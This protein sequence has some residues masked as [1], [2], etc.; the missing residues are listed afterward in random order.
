MGDPIEVEGIS[1]VFHHKTGRPTLIGAIKPSLGHSEGASGIT[2]IMKVVLA[3]EQ[4]TVPATT[5]VNNIKPSIKTDE[6]NV[7]IAMAHCQ[8]PQSLVP[9]ASVNSFGFG[10]AN[11]HAILEAP[12]AHT[13]VQNGHAA[14]LNR[15]SVSVQGDTDNTDYLLAFSARTELSLKQMV[16]DLASHVSQ[17]NE[18]IDLQDLAYT[19]SRHRSRLTTRGYL[20]A[21]QS[22]LQIDLDP[23]RLNIENVGVST[24][25][26]LAFVYTG[27]GA[28]WAGMGWRLIHQ[29]PVFR[30]SIRC[31]DSCLR[32]LGSDLAP[33]WNL[34]ASLL[35]PVEA[36]DIHLAEKS[37]PVCTAVQ[38]ALTDLLHN[39][40]VL[41]K[42]VI[43]HSSGEIG[44]AYAA[45]HLTA[46]QAI[47]TAFCRGLA[48]SK[49]QSIG[50]MVAVGLS[51]SRAQEIINELALQDNINVACINSP[52]SCTVSGDDAAIEKLHDALQKRKIF[53][54][55][56]KTNG[57]AYHSHHMKAVGPLY[58]SMLESVWHAPNDC[59]NG[60]AK[61][62]SNSEKTSSVQMVS[63]VTGM[64]VTPA[65]VSSPAYW[66]E[67]LESPVRF[68]DA[69]RIVLE[70]QQHHFIEVGPH[71]SLKLPIEQTATD[72]DKAHENYL[73][74]S[75]LVRDR[76][77]VVTALNL[78]G[79]L[80]LHGHDEVL[81][82]KTI[83]SG[84][85]SVAQRPSFLV[86]LPTYPWD[87]STPT[88]WHEPRSVTEFRNRRYPRHELLGSQMPGGSKLT[89]TWRSI[90]D[91]KEVDW[92]KDHRLGPSIVFPAPAYLAMAVEAMCQVSGLQL[93]ECPGIE[94]RNFTF[95]KALDLDPEQ[96]PRV[97]IFTEMRQERISST[98]ASER[99][100]HFSVTSVSGNDAYPTAHANGLVRLSKRSP[101]SVH[102]QIELKRTNMEQQATRVWYDKF[103]KE[104]L[105]WGP[106]FAVMEEIFCDRARQAHH[107]SATTH[108]LCGNNS[109]PGGRTQYIAH[110]I[111]ID[112]MLQTA[113]VATTGGWVKNLQ[114]TVP[115]T[116]DSVHVSAPAM[117]DMSTGEQWSIDAVSE[118]VGFGTVRIDAELHNSSNQVLMRMNNVR[119]IAYQGNVQS[120]V[121]E[122]R[123]P[124][125]RVAWKPNITAFAAGANADF[126]KY[127]DWFAESCQTGGMKED[128]PSKRIAAA[129]DLVVHKWPNMRIL[130][131]GGQPEVSGLF[132]DV[133]RAESPL[134]RFSSYVRGIPTAKG[135]LLGL[136][137][138]TGEISFAEDS[139]TAESLP[140]DKKFDLVIF[141]GV[142][143][144][145]KRVVTVEFVINANS[146]G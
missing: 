46:R 135:E 138:L 92:L 36:S 109:G 20:L 140:M 22:S 101:A 87:Y 112:S 13:P 102:R 7:E 94:L 58:Q 27:Q 133:L 11:S 3:L 85:E 24:K 62:A 118:R 45:D 116:M 71:P 84:P 31:L 127:L 21:S 117:L 38:I 113:F 49:S 39:W 103:T 18:L 19:L 44:A 95:L 42:V 115:V 29:Y 34:E 88:P 122:Q 132:I 120:E 80:F 5:G 93:Y 121:V 83:A 123:N 4:H 48:V 16:V 107:A 1:R 37:Q 15:H 141:S 50:A 51:Q 96:R 89:T 128:G 139:R 76:D 54:R 57:K 10:G 144:V 43:G 69:V 30:N 86:D 52:E 72:L 129:L 73:H 64:N 26:P 6:W 35:A 55:K 90:L 130:E 53:A 81:F 14:L 106:Q 59:A 134:R 56:L 25:H 75:V 137:A 61:D 9:R 119:C 100:W 124:L 142:S 32:T 97:E 12:D 41:P 23:S 63:T 126:S 145:Y 40:G 8:W 47:M 98:T 108:L 104:G 91:I 114:A 111:S 74:S 60:L 17:L 2:S 28:Q 70:G 136:E 66:R 68:E 77:A 33:P 105:N 143:A 67:N 99:W 82:E 78:I 125:A 131:L 146:L 79:T 110:P 65:T